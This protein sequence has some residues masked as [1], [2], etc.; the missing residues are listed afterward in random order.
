MKVFLALSHRKLLK[1]RTLVVA[2]DHG[3]RNIIMV[4]DC[5]SMIQRIG[6]P[7]KDRSEVGAV[8]SDIK[9]L[10]RSSLPVPSSIMVVI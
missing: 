6:S 2:K 3:F 1:Q 5:L 7:E 9:K 4:S 8:V 10:A